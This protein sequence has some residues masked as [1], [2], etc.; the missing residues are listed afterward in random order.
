MY[1]YKNNKLGEVDFLIENKGSVIPVEVKSGKSYKKH[2]AIDNLLSAE[3]GIDKGY[4]LSNE[5]IEV[6][7]NL[8]YLPIY[9]VMFFKKDEMKDMEYKIDIS[10]LK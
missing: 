4:I 7:G 3:Y 10:D 8:I 6:D 2:I 1:Y 9:M 5:N